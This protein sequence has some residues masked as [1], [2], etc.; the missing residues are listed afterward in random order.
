M[1]TEPKA[2]P[3]KVPRGHRN[4]AKPG[5]PGEMTIEVR[6]AKA[7]DLRIS[8]KSIRAIAEELGVSV[9]T[10]HSDLETVLVRSRDEAND[11]IQVERETSVARLELAI[12][13][14]MPKV[15]DGNLDACDCLVRLEGRLA[16]LKGTDAPLKQELSGPEGAPIAV[17]VKEDLTRKLEDLGKRLAGGSPQSS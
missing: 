9:G 3:L 1:A 15:L 11:K 10:V 14:I 6:Q 4:R 12:E 2:R 5:T 17:S 13:R 16:K 7:T 8:G